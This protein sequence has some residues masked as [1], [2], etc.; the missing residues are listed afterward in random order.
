MEFQIIMAVYVSAPVLLRFDVATLSSALACVF[1]GSKSCGN[2]T[3]Y[4]SDN[5]I[6]FFW[7]GGGD[8]ILVSYSLATD[9]LLF[10]TLKQQLAPS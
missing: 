3:H 7:G 8:S 9:L 2:N 10:C 4:C 1:P 6:V 5:G